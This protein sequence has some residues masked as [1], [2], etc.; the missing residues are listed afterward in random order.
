[1]TLR[2]SV[3]LALH[4]SLL[5]AFLGCSDTNRLKTYSASGKVVFKDGKPL[6]GGT[7]LFE[8]V[9][10]PVTARATIGVDGGFQLGT[11]EESDGAVAGLHKVA[12]APAMDMTVDRDEVRPPRLIHDRFRDVEMSGLE[13]DVTEDGPNEFEVLVSKK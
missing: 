6:E 7:I 1:M 4:C 13:F 12:I 9:D 2:V 10:Q 5:L 3:R 11:Y 8:S